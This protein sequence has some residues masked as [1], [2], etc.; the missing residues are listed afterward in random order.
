MNG[1]KIMLDRK[2]FI[3]M[4]IKGCFGSHTLAYCDHLGHVLRLQNHRIRVVL[5]YLSIGSNKS[6]VTTQTM[7][8]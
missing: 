6:P 8:V 3:D 2:K 5:K 4:H 7:G 1:K